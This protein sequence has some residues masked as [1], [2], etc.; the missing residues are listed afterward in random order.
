MRE[1]LAKTTEQ[2]KDTREKV[3]PRLHGYAS[4]GPHTAVEC[5]PELRAELDSLALPALLAG[6]K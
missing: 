2:L 4:A 1:E 6:A 3:G 5:F